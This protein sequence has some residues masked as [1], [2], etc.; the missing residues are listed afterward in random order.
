VKFTPKSEGMYRLLVKNK[1][2]GPN[3]VTLAVKLAE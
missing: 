1:G 2:P 3:N